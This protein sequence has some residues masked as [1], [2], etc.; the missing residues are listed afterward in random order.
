[1]CIPISTACVNI[2]DEI[3]IKNLHFLHLD[4]TTTTYFMLR[5][6]VIYISLLKGHFLS[7]LAEIFV[8]LEQRFWASTLSGQN[9][10]TNFGPP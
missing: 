7:S 6:V 1:M 4:P 3:R 2:E 10:L 9:I 8:I 5:V